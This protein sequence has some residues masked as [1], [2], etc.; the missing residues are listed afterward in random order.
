MGF[1]LFDS[2][3]VMHTCGHFVQYA[4]HP[5]E[6]ATARVRIGVSESKRVCGKCI[7]ASPKKPVRVAPSGAGVVGSYRNGPHGYD[8]GMGSDEKVKA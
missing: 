7:A 4:P 8:D 6:S 1:D 3:D 2:I 5:A